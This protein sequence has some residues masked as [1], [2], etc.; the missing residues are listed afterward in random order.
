MS[1][2]KTGAPSEGQ[3]STQQEA[4]VNPSLMD[5]LRELLNE[6][7]KELKE[8]NNKLS[9]HLQALELKVQQSLN[10]N[11]DSLEQMSCERDN[12]ATEAGRKEITPP[13]QQSRQA[14]SSLYG[15]SP[16]F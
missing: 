9:D 2:T 15:P 14:A 11:T 8:D 10:R 1:Q 16:F 12:H 5:Q 4:A 3:V 6:S 7:M 13:E